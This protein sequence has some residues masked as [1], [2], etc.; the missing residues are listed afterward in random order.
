MDNVTNRYGKEIDLAKLKAKTLSS[1]E[2]HLSKIQSM[3]A[4]LKEKYTPINQD[5]C[6]ICESSERTS[7]SNI[8]GFEYVKCL[9]CNHLYTTIRYTEEAIQ[10]FYKSNKYYSQ[11]TY[12]NKET[13]HYRKENVAKPKVQFAEQFVRKQNKKTWLDVGS[14]IGD[15]V[16]VLKENGWDATGLELSETSIAFSKETFNVS[17]VRST[18]GE[19]LKA[20]HDKVFDVISFIGVLEHVPNPLELLQMAHSSLTG[21]GIIMLQVPNAFSLTS[22]LQSLFYN[23]VFR[24]MSPLE[25]IMLFSKD[26]LCKALETTGFKPLSFWWHGMDIYELLNNLTLINPKVQNSIFSQNIIDNMNELQFVLDR[27]EL[28]DRIICVA[29]KVTSP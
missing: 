11:I 13:C 5:E 16:S 17:L 23:N 26:S 18:F 7:F 28:S 25:H 4:S 12:A 19:Y 6:Y 15:L 21:K 10:N 27:K 3:I 9:H 14:G 29:K 8:Y 20:N 1:L 24:H 22:H 2:G